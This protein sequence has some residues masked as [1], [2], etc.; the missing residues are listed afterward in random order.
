MRGT[1]QRV[2]AVVALAGGVAAAAVAVMSALGSGGQQVSS[3]RAADATIHSHVVAFGRRRVAVRTLPGRVCFTIWDGAGNGRGCTTST[4]RDDI[5]FALSPHG[6]G[7]VAG[8]GVRAV[9]VKLT[10][11]GTAWATLRDGAFYADIP[12]GHAVR[13]VIKVL[14]G[15]ARKTFVVTASWR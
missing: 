6:I 3:A 9:I 2:L 5:D 15:G 4:G 11:K 14:R 12:S 8:T 1:V 13:R 10:H 7:G